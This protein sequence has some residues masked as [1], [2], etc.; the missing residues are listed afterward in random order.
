[1]SACP[2]REKFH[3]GRPAFSARTSRCLR[4]CS[5]R[6]RISESRNASLFGGPATERTATAPVSA[7]GSSRQRCKACGLT[8]TQ[9]H[10]ATG[11]DHFAQIERGTRA[12]GAAAD[13]TR[14]VSGSQRGS[15]R[16][17]GLRSSAMLSHRRRSCQDRHPVPPSGIWVGRGKGTCRSCRTRLSRCPDVYTLI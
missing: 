13:H 3:F 17:G 9:Q 12:A 1:M 5:A 7:W 15:N 10:G 6:G 11:E 16:V 4:C 14:P 8:G 2:H